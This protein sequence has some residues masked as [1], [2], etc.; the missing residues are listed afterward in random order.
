MSTCPFSM[1][2]TPANGIEEEE[3]SFI[4]SS[5]MILIFHIVYQQK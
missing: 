1:S 3:P 4:T 5:F 2:K